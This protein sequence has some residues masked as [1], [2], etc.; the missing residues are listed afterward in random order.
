MHKQLNCQKPIIN[1]RQA[2]NI[3]NYNTRYAHFL[4]PNRQLNNVTK[5]FIAQRGC[6]LWNALPEALKLV[7]N[8]GTF[9]IKAKK[10]L[11]S[12]YLMSF[13]QK[14]IKIIVNYIVNYSSF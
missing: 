4:R 14:F 12:Q 11:I 9:K 8:P 6:M 2:N 3:H 13:K 5:N 10:H 7:V 1:Y